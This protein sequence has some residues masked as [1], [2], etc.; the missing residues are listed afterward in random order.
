MTTLS[1]ALE[2]NRKTPIMNIDT[3]I[4]TYDYSPYRL[5]DGSELPAFEIFNESGDKIADMNEH[6]PVEFQERMATLLMQAPEMLR[7]LKAARCEEWVCNAAITED[8]EALRRI[9]LHYASWWNEQVLPL[10]EC[11]MD[12]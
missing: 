2:H 4:L 3:L 9:C 8:R 6:Q 10:I 7:L 1:S 11:F 12:D 5:Q